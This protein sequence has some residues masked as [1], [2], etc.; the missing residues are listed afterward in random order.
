[1]NRERILA[2]LGEDW[3]RACGLMASSLHTDVELLA[4]I[5]SSVFSHTGKMLRP[6][7][8]LLV[9]RACGKVTEDT[10]R[11]AAAVEMLHNATLIHDDVA[12]ESDERRGRPSI[13]AMLG[14]TNA[15][16]VGDFWL[17]KV[18]ELAAVSQ[19]RDKVYGMLSANLVAL[20]EGEM[21]QLE[22]T[23]TADTSEADYLRIITCKTAKLFESAAAIAAI[24]SDAPQE[25][26]DAA[27]R[28]GLSVGMAFQISDDILDY[29]GGDGLGKPLGA[30][31]KEQ[32]ITLPL[33]GALASCDDPQA[34]RR[35]VLG[36]KE[37]PE[38]EGEIHR[39]VME[40][41]GVEYA[42]RRLE[43]YIDD[44]VDALG[45]FPESEARGHLESMARYIS[46]RGI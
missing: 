16:L 39:F 43:E 25:L 34:I 38:Y 33:L 20:A 19:R 45:A 40:S 10:I 37:H 35:K 41:G 6:M 36:L 2:Y 8:S 23:G 11:Y 4:G 46:I 15:V 42:N 24:A 5:N 17:A 9:S 1:M 31:L 27:S 29:S 22:K 14:P 28:F 7:M 26:V 21:L 44:A 12:D 13:R 30:D 32:K 3:T 18:V